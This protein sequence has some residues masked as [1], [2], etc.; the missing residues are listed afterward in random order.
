MNK[1]QFFGGTS[2]ASSSTPYPKSVSLIENMFMVLETHQFN[3]SRL[4]NN[5]IIAYYCTSWVILPLSRR[6]TREIREFSQN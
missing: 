5:P 2:Q 6:Y 3:P 1:N 4:R